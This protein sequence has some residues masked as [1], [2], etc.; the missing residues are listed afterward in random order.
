M[1][2]I[3]IFLYT[4]EDI[5]LMNFN[6]FDVVRI[7]V[8]GTGKSHFTSGC[9]GVIRNIG[10]GGTRSGVYYIEEMYRYDQF[11]FRVAG[12]A[13]W[14]DDEDLSSTNVISMETG[15]KLVRQ[16]EEDWAH[17]TGV[18]WQTRKGDRIQEQLLD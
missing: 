17:K 7:E 6:V 5:L 1:T 14:Y 12:A 13:S 10:S 9:F 2:W 15:I 4:V 11:Y 18:I 16:Y 8:A 3:A